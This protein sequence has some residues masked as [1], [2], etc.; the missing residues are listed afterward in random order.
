MSTPNTMG[1]VATVLNLYA[2]GK[3]GEPTVENTEL[4]IKIPV[5]E[6]EVGEAAQGLYEAQKR[7]GR[8]TCL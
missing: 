5:D 4:G 3:R 1:I 2:R 6:W 7:R 8:K